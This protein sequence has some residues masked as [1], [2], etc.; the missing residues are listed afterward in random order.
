MEWKDHS[1]M[2]FVSSGHQYLF[3]FLCVKG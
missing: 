3:Q 1:F 2:S